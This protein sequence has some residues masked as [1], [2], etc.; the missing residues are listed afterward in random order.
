MNTLRSEDYLDILIF[1]KEDEAKTAYQN[2]MEDKQ[3]LK[4]YMNITK[5]YTKTYKAYSYS[6]NRYIVGLSLR[7]RMTHNITHHALFIPF[8]C[9]SLISEGLFE[10]FMDFD[11]IM[12]NQVIRSSMYHN[13]TLI[14]RTY[15]QVWEW[16]EEEYINYSDRSVYSRMKVILYAVVAFGTISILSSF[17][18]RISLMVSTAIVMLCG[19]FLF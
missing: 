9:F 10:V 8:S 12:V 17:I 4:E 1:Y 15:N 6:S 16:S 14:D 2:Y 3:S 13:G 11:I 5:Y 19:I 18:I 7:T